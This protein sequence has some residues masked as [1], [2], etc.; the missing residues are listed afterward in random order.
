MISHVFL[1]TD[2]GGHTEEEEQRME[3]P[4][5]TWVKI[6]LLSLSDVK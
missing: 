1:K 4:L 5:L 3:D 6:A 2:D